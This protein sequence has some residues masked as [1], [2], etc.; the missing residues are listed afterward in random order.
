[1]KF[2]DMFFLIIVLLI[3]A[4]LSEPKADTVQDRPS[5]DTIDHWKPYTEEPYKKY[6]W[7]KE[8]CVCYE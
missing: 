5:Y 3:F 7:E 2:L 4:W 6:D 8:H 1:M